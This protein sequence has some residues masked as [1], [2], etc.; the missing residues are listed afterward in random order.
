M[1]EKLVL[2]TLMTLF[3]VKCNGDY[4]DYFTATPQ[5]QQLGPSSVEQPSLWSPGKVWALH[6]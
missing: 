2:V 1:L 5:Q 6:V 3:C 4:I